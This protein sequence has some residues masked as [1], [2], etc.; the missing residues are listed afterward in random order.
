MARFGERPPLTN[1][2]T[3]TIQ[4]TIVMPVLAFV[5]IVG[6]LSLTFSASVERYTQAYNVT[7]DAIRTWSRRAS[8]IPSA[9]S[10]WNCSLRLKQVNAPPVNKF[11]SVTLFLSTTRVC[12]CTM[13]GH[14]YIITCRSKRMYSHYNGFFYMCCDAAQ[15]VCAWQKR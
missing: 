14:G 3:S 5:V 11:V 6:T 15:R 13:R 2:S 10:C 9:T 8:H 12:V 1:T 7:Q 4:P